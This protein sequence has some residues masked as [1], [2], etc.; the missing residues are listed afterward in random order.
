MPNTSNEA[1]YPRIC[2]ESGLTCEGCTQETARQLAQVC[3]GL[4][5][6]AIGQLFVQIHSHPACAP[7]HANFAATYREASSERPKAMAAVA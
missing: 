6:K 4:R 3:R 5:G 1:N 7:M 2:F